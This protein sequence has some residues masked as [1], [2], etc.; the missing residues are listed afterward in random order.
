MLDIINIAPKDC[1]VMNALLLRL[2]ILRKGLLGFHLN[3]AK[4]RVLL[5]AVPAPDLKGFGLAV[6][7]LR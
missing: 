3:L 6:F 1:L 7:L 4:I 5:S 2:D